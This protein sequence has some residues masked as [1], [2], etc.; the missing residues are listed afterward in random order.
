[1]LVFDMEDK[2]DIDQSFFTL[3]MV[4]IMQDQDIKG[5]EVQVSGGIHA[6]HHPAGKGI[7]GNDHAVLE[8]A[9]LPAVRGCEML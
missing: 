9:E 5:A 8:L 7:M 1:M 6:T 4:D 3:P 2:A